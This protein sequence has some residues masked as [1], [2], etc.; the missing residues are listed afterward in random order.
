MGKK[1]SEGVVVSDSD[2]SMEDAPETTSVNTK[3]NAKVSPNQGATESSSEFDSSDESS[4]ETQNNN[5]VPLKNKKFVPPSGFRPS[6][7][8]P[9]PSAAISS[10]L[11]NLEGKQVFHIT[12]PSYLPLSEMKQITFGKA[13]SGEPII[14]HK[15]VD[16]GLVETTRQQK[17]S[18]ETLLIYD[19]KSNTY[20]RKPELRKIES[21]NIQEIVRLPGLDTLVPP[22]QNATKKQPAARP[23]PKHLRMRFHPVGST[24]LPPE[25]VGSSS[26]SEA[27]EP[28]S[29]VPATSSKEK[30]EK[31]RKR[32]TDEQNGTEEKAKK[33]K[34]DKQQSSQAELQTEGRR[35]KEKKSS[36]HRDET[37]QERRARKEEKKKRKAEKV[38]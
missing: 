35:D 25:T 2:E 26:E 14:S 24:T 37:S 21:Y 22:S 30:A 29:R 6:T 34:K 9:R 4:S 23:Q 1:L 18:S 3:K 38:K 15:G 32:K 13:T 5:S 33:S 36:K 8:K 20:L 19:E 10:A 27:D 7:T 31:D 16:Y 28:T 17:Q 11:S 12:A